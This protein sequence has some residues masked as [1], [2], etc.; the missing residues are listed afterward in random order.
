MGSRWT[1][2]YHAPA[3]FD[4]AGLRTALQAA[5][6]RVDDQMSSWK[7][8]SDLNRLNAAPVGRWIDL[9][10][11]LA[12][13]LDAALAVGTAS[14]GAFDIGVGDL[15]RA[16]GFGAGAGMPDPAAAAQAAHL[17]LAS[18]PQSLELDCVNRRARK[19]AA[20]R[21]D[22]SGIAKGFGVDEL[23]RAMAAAGLRSWLVGIDGEMLAR[24]TKPGGRPWA[25]AHESPRE[26][27]REIAGILEL[28]DCAVA[29][30]GDYRHVQEVDGRRVSHT[31]DPRRNAPLASD[32]ASVTV[33][34]DTCMAADA[35]ATAILVAG[36][37]AGREL[38]GRRGL[39]V[40][41]F[42][43]NGAMVLSLEGRSR[44]DAV[45]R[46]P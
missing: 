17:R 33:L 8:G 11:E 40:L 41:A 14:G 22:L 9:P 7:P 45:A 31:M 43:R 29:T 23:G 1:A 35:W 21:L 30:S 34:A 4:A 26:G 12:T 36:A 20:L 2:V 42:D 18:P 3:S 16:W 6:D 44:Q 27:H 32:L 5:V 46:H 13:V 37:A 39:R 28:V 19:H 25:I 38:A 15:V 24:G 10:V